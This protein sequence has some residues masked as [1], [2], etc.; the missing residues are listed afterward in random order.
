MLLKL[1][2]IM[3]ALGQNMLKLIKSLFFI[4]VSGFLYMYVHLCVR[5]PP[6][7][8]AQTELQQDFQKLSRLSYER[9]L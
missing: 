9:V 8:M 6:G 5:L 2:E 1:S 4:H 7:R 3:E